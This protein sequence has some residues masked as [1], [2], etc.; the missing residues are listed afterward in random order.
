MFF[1]LLALSASLVVSWITFGTARRFVR[2]R[3]R[4]VDAALRPSAPII[5]GLGVALLAVPIFN[6]LHLIPLVGAIVGGGTGLIAAIGA[7]LG[8]RQGATDIRNG[9]VIGAGR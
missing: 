6:L 5:A 9:Y 8:V 2:Q 3:L 7:G 1:S 4:Y